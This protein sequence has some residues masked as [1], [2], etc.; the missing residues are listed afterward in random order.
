MYKEKNGFKTILSLLLFVTLILAMS[1][2][3][4]A[5]DGMIDDSVMTD[6]IDKGVDDVSFSSDN[7]IADTESSTPYSVDDATVTED[8]EPIS[9]TE[10]DVTPK[11]PLASTSGSE[12]NLGAGT[13]DVTIDLS[14]EKL[15]G[16][17]VCNFT[18]T[19]NETNAGGS[20]KVTIVDTCVPEDPNPRTFIYNIPVAGGV[21]TASSATSITV[22]GNQ[23]TFDEVLLWPSFR[24]EWVDGVQRFPDSVTIAYSGDDNYAP[25]TVEKSLTVYPYEAEMEIDIT[26]GQGAYNDIDY[27]E[28]LGLVKFEVYD[29]FDFNNPYYGGYFNVYIVNGDEV[30]PDEFNPTVDTDKILNKTRIRV[31]D[32]DGSF[33]YDNIFD[34]GYYLIGIYFDEVNFPRYNVWEGFNIVRQ[35]Q[36]GPFVVLSNGLGYPTL[37]EAIAAAIE[38]DNITVIEEGI[39]KGI[40]NTGLIIEKSINIAAQEGLNVVFDCENLNNFITVTADK[41]VVLKDITVTNGKSEKGGAVLVKE[42]GKLACECVNFTNN[43]ATLSGGAIYAEDGSSLVIM[44]SEFISNKALDGTAGAIWAE[45]QDGK[46]EECS[47]ISN[48]ATSYG[49]AI[50]LQGANCTVKYCNFTSNKAGENM[51]GN[52]IFWYGAQGRLENSTFDSNLGGVSAILWFGNEGN[53]T[54]SYFKNNDGDPAA[55]N[56]FN[57]TELNIEEN[58]FVISNVSIKA[59][60]DIYPSGDDAVITGNFNWGVYSSPNDLKVDAKRDFTDIGFVIENFNGCNFTYELKDLLSGYYTLAIENF[61]DSK[62]NRFIIE[63]VARADFSVLGNVLVPTE[64]VITVSD[65]KYGEDENAVVTLKASDGT[66]LNGVVKLSIGDQVQNIT[67]ENGVGQ[68]KFTNLSANKY[69]AIAQFDGDDTYASSFATAPIVVSKLKTRIVCKNMTTTAI[70]VTEDGRIGEYFTWTL[71]DEKGRPLEGKD[72]SIGFNANVYNR[73]TNAS[74]QARLQINLQ[75][76]GPYTFAIAFLGDENYDGSFEVLKITVNKQKASLSA[77]SQT[78]K[79]S[80]KTKTLAATYKTK[81]GKAIVGKTVKFTVNGKT[82]SAKTDSSGVAKV[83]VSL[84]KAGSY[85]VEVKAPATNTYAEVTKKVTLKLT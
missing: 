59:D 9:N 18:I 70:N 14:Q 23:K 40:Q 57:V 15:Y 63:T 61:T 26:K 66:L 3:S 6:Q 21:A 82:Y 20:V 2:A 29:P 79:A 27:G 75:N 13:Q 72:V 7:I 39:Y 37:E 16:G 22:D 35:A 46:I 32:G 60:G 65:I 48:E 12:D 41:V 55:F 81:A 4:A 56:I 77:S 31:D 54:G 84:T 74:G 49:G 5:D 51:P 80:A 1:S 11:A 19:F 58:T 53:I 62:N 71:V 36:T 83:N 78:Y 33:T 43:I 25:K 44:S 8:I 67:V 73:V 24:D 50:F 34:E 30:D 10:S 45:G 28:P 38:G 68:A 69:V 85:T 64:M 52:A 17:D 42:G 47:F 76:S